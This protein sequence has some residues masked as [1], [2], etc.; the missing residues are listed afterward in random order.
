MRLFF[1]GKLNTEE[2]LVEMIKAQDATVMPDCLD[3]LAESILDIDSQRASEL[4]KAA[5]WLC[6]FHGDDMNKQA[7]SEFYIMVYKRGI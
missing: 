2:C 6:D 5:Y 3:I 4:L 7:L 1:S